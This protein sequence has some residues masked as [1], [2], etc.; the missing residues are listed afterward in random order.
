MER[1][2]ERRVEH[3]L[4]YK[5]PVKF[6]AGNKTRFYNGQIVDLSSKGM[7]FLCHADQSGFETGQ[8]LKTSFGVP[9]FNLSD[10]FDTILFERIGHVTRIEKPAGQVHRIAIQ[11]ASPLFFKP[12]EQQI[13]EDEAR[14]RLDA[15]NFSIIKSEETARAYTEALSKAEKKLRLYAQAKAK[16]EER[17]KAEIEDRSGT[18]ANLRAEAEEKMLLFE[19]KIARLEENLRTRDKEIAKIKT[20]LEISEKKTKSLE[21]QLSK[22]KNET[23]KKIDRIKKDSADM[24]DKIKSNLN[25]VP[26]Q[27]LKKD[28]L[29]KVDGFFSDK[30]KIF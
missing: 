30:N 17:L 13:N 14:Q 24:I 19:E 21:E 15:K 3:R 4:Q 22:I 5:W 7:A 20:A 8:E 1:T 29:K 16:A 23:D 12:G 9:F 27:Y 2:Y 11:F 28:L 26:K 25:S 10:L 18:E 6:S